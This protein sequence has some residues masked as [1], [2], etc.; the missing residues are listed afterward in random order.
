MSRTRSWSEKLTLR[1][2]QSPKSP[3]SQP[4]A[5]RAVPSPPMR[6]AGVAPTRPQAAANANR[7]AP[8][9]PPH[10][11][12]LGGAGFL[13]SHLTAALVAR[14]VHVRVFDRPTASLSAI[15]ELVRRQSTSGGS[16]HVVT[17]DLVNVADQAAAVHGV[18]VVYHLVSTTNPATSSEDPS[19][20]VSSNLV[21]TVQL[22][23][24]CV[25]AGV[26][27]VVFV[28][29][30]GTVY[31]R[32]QTLPIPETHP[33]NPW[34]SYGIVKVAIEHYL[35]LYRRLHGIQ[36]T[37]VRLAN[38]F[39]PY[40]RVRGAQ[41]AATV[42]LT[43]AHDRLPIE[44]WG[45]GTIVRD[46]VYVTDAVDGILAAADRGGEA[47]L[48]NVGSGTGASLNELV[49]TIGRVADRALDV[50]YLEGRPFDVPVNIL[51]IARAR[52]DLGWVPTVSLEEGLRLTW[53]WLDGR[54][55]PAT[56]Q[57]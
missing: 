50:R 38:P 1:L 54:V 7:G 29:S 49:T 27:Q 56:P 23:D 57:G 55:A 34:C 40:Q 43:R 8:T 2:A 52:V 19:Y 12:V 37:A 14:G 36:F 24:A 30:G 51:D 16:W 48:F 42:F 25:V 5:V 53:E 6:T 33:T 18:D 11:V 3:S 47:G 21:A 4:L 32:P 31:G 20:D 41:G 39:G 9:E 45:D 44:I 17:G 10:A 28:S 22:L 46:Y 35:R 15:D 26:R 13:G